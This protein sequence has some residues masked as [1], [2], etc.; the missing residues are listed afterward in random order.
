MLGARC[1]ARLGSA[2][3]LNGRIF[4]SDVSGGCCCRTRRCLAD[5]RWASPRPASACSSAPR[6]GC[7]CPSCEPLR[8][9]KRDAA[10]AQSPANEGR[11]G[12]RGQSP[13]SPQ[14]GSLARWRSGATQTM[15]IRS[16]P[17]VG[18]SLCLDAAAAVVAR[19]WFFL[20]RCDEMTYGRRRACGAQRDLAR[21]FSPARE[22]GLR[23]F[24]ERGRNVKPRNRTSGMRPAPCL[25]QAA[26]YSEQAQMRSLGPRPARQLQIA[27]PPANKARRAC[28]HSVR[29]RGPIGAAPTGR[30]RWLGQ[31]ASAATED[32]RRRCQMLGGAR[33]LRA[34]CFWHGLAPALLG[35]WHLGCW[36]RLE[37]RCR[38]WRQIRRQARWLAAGTL[39]HTR[40]LTF[41]TRRCGVHMSGCGDG[42]VP[43]GDG[44]RLRGSSLLGRLLAGRAGCLARHA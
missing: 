16:D 9:R 36:L 23:I 7:K 19:S 2:E 3:K 32:R 28:R 20:C 14:A 6:R 39:G 42:D 22:Q 1:D 33:R 43:G 40:T 5:G 26:A 10:H 8:V 44:G 18:C 21:S 31:A 29:R 15:H 11:R 27:A 30:R 4:T 37:A 35:T 25:C 41:V 38:R 12:Q 34:L 17:P 24:W 13:A